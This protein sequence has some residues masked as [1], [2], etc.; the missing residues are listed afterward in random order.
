MD[1][2]CPQVPLGISG[3]PE[4]ET[5]SPLVFSQTREPT[6]MVG[7]GAEQVVKGPDRVRQRAG[8]GGEI[9]VGVFDF[10]WTWRLKWGRK[11]KS[12]NPKVPALLGFAGWRGLSRTCV[13]L[14]TGPDRLRR[15]TGGSPAG[16]TCP[17]DFLGGPRPPGLGYEKRPL[18]SGLLAG[19]RGRSRTADPYRVKVVLYP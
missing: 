6:E 18:V 16:P 12:Q 9:R 8:G 11:A 15:S 3:T 19:W 13:R 1:R 4:G 10:P 2:E 7:S 17:P 14:G 5:P